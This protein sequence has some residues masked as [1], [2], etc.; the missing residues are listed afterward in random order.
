[1]DPIDRT[2]GIRPRPTLGRRLDAVSR[3]AFPTACTVLLMMLT[4]APFGVPDQAELLPAVAL[5]CVWFWSLFRPSSV[6]P[7]TVFLIGL[8]FDLLGYIPIGVGVLTLLITH[9]VAVRWRRVLVRQGFL[10]VW[11]AFAGIAAGAAALNWA[12][13]SLLVFR[14]LPVGA[15]IFQCALSVA[16]YPPLATLFT[17][18]HRSLAAPERA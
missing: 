15:A 14:V 18:A 8:L 16:A 9:G 17:R 1:L 7:P 2:P 11:L 13:T 12:M 3:A 4:A 5:S 10:V 6:P